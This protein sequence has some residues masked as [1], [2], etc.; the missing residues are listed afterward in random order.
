M[1]LTWTLALL[2]GGL[3]AAALGRWQ[4]ARPRELGEVRLVSPTFLLGAGVLLAVL[5]LAH[6]VALL[7]GAP[8]EGR[9]PF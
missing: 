8:L 7:T 5:A 4:E 2:A 6:L 9:G 1:T 3:A